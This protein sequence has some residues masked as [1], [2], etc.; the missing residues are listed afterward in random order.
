MDIGTETRLFAYPRS[1]WFSSARFAVAE[2]E[3]PVRPSA[4]LFVQEDLANGN[5]LRLPGVVH[6]TQSGNYANRV[7][8]SRLC[9][10]RFAWKRQAHFVFASG[11]VHTCVDAGGRREH[12]G[13]RD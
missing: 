3:V 9:L 10:A 1:R 2:T 4:I 6:R 8:R 12:Y 13:R 11:F 7:A 5:H